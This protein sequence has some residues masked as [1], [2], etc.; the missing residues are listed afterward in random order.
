MSKLKQTEVDLLM[1][2][3]T[4]TTKTQDAFA[5]MLNMTRQN[6]NRIIREAHARDGKLLPK[7]IARLNQQYDI[8]IY[9]FKMNPTK[10]FHHR[11][12]LHHT[13]LAFAEP[14]GNYLTS[15]TWEYL[16]EEN[17]DLKQKLLICQEALNSGKKENR[18]SA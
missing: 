16:I 14:E 12:E 10:D 1:L 2:A 15:R 3:I 13:G 6:L 7:F 4:A 5:K 9:Q 8:D 18:R 11:D 17:R